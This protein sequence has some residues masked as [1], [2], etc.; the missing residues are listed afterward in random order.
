MGVFRKLTTMSSFF[1]VETAPNES[2]FVNVS[3]APTTHSC[4]RNL[5]K[6][7]VDRL[8][9]KLTAISPSSSACFTFQSR[10]KLDG[11]STKKKT[12]SHLSMPHSPRKETIDA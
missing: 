1:S 2:F 7:E 9:K 4:I 12:F 5:L 6:K 3:R 11:Q 10:L 8:S